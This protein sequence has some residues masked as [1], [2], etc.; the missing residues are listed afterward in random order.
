MN[1]P[2]EHVVG[3]SQTRSRHSI[4]F[5]SVGFGALPICEVGD[6]VADGVCD[7]APCGE[8]DQHFCSEQPQC[9]A[10]LSESSSGKCECGN[11]WQKCC[12]GACEDNLA[13]DLNGDKYGQCAPCGGVYPTHYLNVLP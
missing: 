8:K 11:M 7:S 6:I 9:K 13:C 5:C 2:S 4:M 12:D 3:E 10:G 1:L